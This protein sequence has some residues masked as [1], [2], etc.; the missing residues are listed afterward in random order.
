MAANNDCSNRILYDRKC[1]AQQL[2]ISVRALDYL[3][4]QQR[5]ATRRIGGRVLVHN[6]ELQ[7]FARGNH[8][9]LIA[10]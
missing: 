5:L 2:S 4:Q 7:R 10:A 6:N 9:E 3:I 8:T 1:A